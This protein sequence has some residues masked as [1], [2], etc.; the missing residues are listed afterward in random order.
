MAS[1]A[2]PEGG[3]RE[4]GRRLRGEAMVDS[5]VDLALKLEERPL[6]LRPVFESNP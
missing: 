2:W 5:Q 6:L 1:D 3:S 4:E